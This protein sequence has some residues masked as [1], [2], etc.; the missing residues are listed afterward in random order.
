[1]SETLP[2]NATPTGWLEQKL[3]QHIEIIMGQAPPGDTCNKDGV[4][5]P[6]VKVGEFGVSRPSIREWTTK[7]LKMAK[8]S[9]VLLC[10]VG[11]TCGKVNRGT[12]CAIGRSVASLRPLN[13]L[14]SEFLYQFMF[15]KTMEM[16]ASSRGSAQG[17]IS[18]I[19]L[20]ELLLPIPTLYEQEKI[21]EI[22]EEQLSR[23]DAALASVR[24][25]RTKAARFR[26][27]LL[28]AAFTGALTGHG[29]SA[30]ALPEGW[31]EK[32]LSELCAPGKD[33]IVDGPFGSNL[34]R[35]DFLD[36]GVPVLK[37][38]NIKPNMI[39]QKNMDFV[40]P[41]KFETLMR[42][43]FR[44]G[45]VVMTK[46][47]N[48]LG[49]SAV[50]TDIEHGVIVADLVRVR[51]ANIDTKFLC[52]QLN[53]PLVSKFINEN[54]KG[55]TRPRINLSIVRNLKLNVP[56]LAEQQKIVEILEEQ[57]SRL[58]A[59]LALADVIEKK[60]SGLRRS[61]LHAAFTGEL[62]KQWREDAHV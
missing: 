3:G 53:S 31:A 22:L 2:T 24:I 18:K 36:S 40:S 20:S 61:L 6:F 19:D 25:V 39:I 47:G 28:H 44:L 23:L 1:M 46:L 14:N 55:T 12:N 11:A 49:V 13:T 7:P 32:P 62:T 43:S 56:R 21:V 10:V 35:S 17:V 60:T 38:Q 37:L 26:R 52:Y 15:F 51:P 8:E 5:T 33:S 59:S 42:H 27:S 4:G 45:D 48:P 29:A 34:K 58:D 16:R 41:A 50:V 57:L 30:G 9:D 54:Q